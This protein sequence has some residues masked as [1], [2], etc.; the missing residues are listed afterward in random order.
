MHLIIHGENDHSPVFAQE[1]QILRAF[2]CAH[3]LNS[4]VAEKTHD[5]VFTRRVFHAYIVWKPHSLQVKP[6]EG[7]WSQV[8][9]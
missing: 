3:F 5:P 2:L 4:T 1:G 8:S 9:S 7:N 6:Q